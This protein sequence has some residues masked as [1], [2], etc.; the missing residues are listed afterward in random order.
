MVGLPHGENGS[1][2]GGGREDHQPGKTLLVLGE[3]T[4]GDMV[5]ALELATDDESGGAVVAV[6]ISSGWVDVEGQLQPVLDLV[7]AAAAAPATGSSDT[8]THQEEL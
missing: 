5:Q 4:V 8:T 1:G 6:R 3:L 7:A 2:G